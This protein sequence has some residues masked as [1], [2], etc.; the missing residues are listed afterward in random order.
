MFLAKLFSFSDFRYEYLQAGAIS[1]I[2]CLFI[3]YRFLSAYNARFSIEKDLD[4]IQSSTVAVDDARVQYILSAVDSAS[5]TYPSTVGRRKKMQNTSATFN[6]PHK[7]ESHSPTIH[8]TMVNGK[9]DE[10]NLQVWF[11]LYVCFT[12]VPDTQA[13]GYIKLTSQSENMV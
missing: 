12:C 4:I 5:S 11:T 9:L 13:N 8:G 7:V 2:L 1:F 10:T 3:F 6:G